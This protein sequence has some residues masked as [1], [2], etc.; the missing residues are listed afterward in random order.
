MTTTSP[1]SYPAPPKFLLGLAVIIWGLLTDHLLTG[2]VTAL[3]VEG[4]H[5]L[6]WRW[7]FKLRGYSRAWIL[8]L[9]VLAGV[10]AYHSLNLSG[11]TAALAFIEW[12]PLIF[13]PLILAQQYGEEE[14]VPT[15][16]FSLVARRRLQRER[17]LGKI[18]PESYIQLGY[19]YFAFILLATG[20]TAS[21]QRD[22][23]TFFLILIALVAF[24]YYFGQQRDQRRLWPTVVAMILVATSSY[25]MSQGLVQLYYWLKH[26]HFLSS[27]GKDLPIQQRTAIGQLGELKQTRRIQWRLN[28]P[29]Q[30]R[31]PKLLMTAGY[32]AYRA[33]KWQAWDPDFPDQDRTYVDLLTLAGE[34]NEGEF[35]FDTQGFELNND[36]SP[37]PPP[38]RIR[39]AIATNEKTLPAPS[40][41]GL[42][43]QAHEIDSIEQNRLGTLLAINAGS[44]VDYH[45]WESRH[46]EWREAPPMEQIRPNE[47]PEIIAL[48]LPNKNEFYNERQAIEEVAEGLKLASLPEE[49]RI[50]TLK[51]Y[52]QEN[53]RYSTHLR[54][55]GADGRSALA[56]FLTETREGHCEYFA[57]ATTLLLRASG[58]PAHYVVGYAVHENSKEPNEYVLRGTH[59][60]AWC[61]AYLGGKSEVIVDER[62]VE[63]NG[64]LTTLSFT[65]VVWS[66]GQ[67][68]DIDLTPPNWFQIDSPPPN[69]KERLADQLQRGREDFQV[70]RSN[71]ANR[72]WVNLLLAVVASA[73]LIFIGWRLMTTRLKKDSP[74]PHSRAE[75]FG[76]R[77]LLNEKIPT[78]EHHLGKRRPGMSLDRWLAENLP[79]FPESNLATILSYQAEQRFADRK[80]THSEYVEFERLI[81]SLV[82]SCS[83][84]KERSF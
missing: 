49:K 58:I 73:V 84:R 24:A 77:T 47:E 2:L 45:V 76:S 38:I 14:A 83:Q 81:E 43:A 67:W 23:L 68:T 46:P 78:L 61:R 57:T 32:N 48:S 16:V 6:N 12:L 52:F 41:P 79:D 21:G 40:S 71:E 22:Q 54:I 19:P 42:F 10:V 60:H 3:L 35:A 37:S 63:K 44:V 26:G 59:A 8:S 11:P 39:G 82:E 69:W 20:F 55:S 50:Q 53:F 18:I 25:F 80:L 66:G 27:Q 28:V 5:W 65:R 51:D 29:K 70:W 15:T 4:R 56:D 62:Q 17:R 34:E 13:L 30:T 33:G 9:I 64:E 36:D 72:G 31:P 74:S 7:Q 75:N 1:S